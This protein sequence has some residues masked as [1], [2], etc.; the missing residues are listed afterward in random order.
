MFVALAVTEPTTLA[1]CDSLAL[2]DAEQVGVCVA[3]APTLT[4]PELLLGADGAEDSAT[5]V[6]AVYDGIAETVPLA[7]AEA[8]PATLADAEAAA[9]A[10]AVMLGVKLGDGVTLGDGDGLT[11]AV[12]MA[13]EVAEA[14]TVGDVAADAVADAAADAL[15]VAETETPQKKPRAR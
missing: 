11:L 12:A 8:D 5:E 10:D 1:D 14:L 15:A 6:L 7:L 4:V 9:L 3:D 13:D 2:A